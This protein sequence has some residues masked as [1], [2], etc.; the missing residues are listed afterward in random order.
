MSKSPAIFVF[1][2]ASDLQHLVPGEVRGAA[3]RGRE[4]AVGPGLA[5]TVFPSGPCW[6][7]LKGRPGVEDTGSPLPQ[8]LLPKLMPLRKRMNGFFLPGPC[9]PP[10]TRPTAPHLPERSSEA[11]V[12]CRVAV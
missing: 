4:A 9:C 7:G 2:G 1:Q 3:P 8:Q 11:V 12:L 6:L 10:Q 5:R